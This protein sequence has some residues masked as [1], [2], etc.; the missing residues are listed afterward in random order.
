MESPAEPER[1]LRGGVRGAR[2][3]GEK[4]EKKKEEEEFLSLSVDQ[5]GH[6]RE[7]YETLPPLPLSHA[8][9]PPLFSLNNTNINKPMHHNR[10][11]LNSPLSETQFF[12][13]RKKEK[14]NSNSKNEQ[15]KK[16]KEKKRKGSLSPSLF[17]SAVPKNEKEKGN[18]TRPAVSTES[19]KG[20]RNEK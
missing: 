4:K 12:R 5:I 8:P 3:I 13:E 7:N 6:T 1:S 11:D 10:P 9:S 17:G 20:K 16:G 14:G 18:S 2:S 19:E 15:E